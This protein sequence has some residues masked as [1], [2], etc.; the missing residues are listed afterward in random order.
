MTFKDL[1]LAGYYYGSLPYR[2]A[3]NAREARMG[4][5]PVSILFYHR[6][7]DEIPND[8]TISSTGFKRHID[9]LESNFE[10]ISLHEAQERL[11]SE[12]NSK[13][14]VCITFDDGYADN[15]AY[16]LPLLLKRE[17]PFTYFVTL[18]NIL[19]GTPFPHDV[20]AGC[21]LGPNTAEQIRE[22]ADAGVE[23]G[24]HT[25]T[26]PHLG[27]ITDETELYDEVVGSSLEL[28]ALTGKPVRY[29]AVPFGLPEHLNP[30]AIAMAREAGM[31]GVCS[32][33]GAL[34][35]PED[36]PFMLHRIH[37]DPELLRVKNWV[38]VDPRKRDAAHVVL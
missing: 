31:L 37:G 16:A 32:A 19:E 36:D 35:F 34:N 28:A 22:L 1:L 7:A 13:P 30:K 29:F 26:H 3:I 23:I 15:C 11:R 2:T 33:F 5:A 38:S 25:R 12:K 27:E 8:W 4:R 18:K 6:V 14:A 9:Y 24:G 21:A 20:A 10:I 17:I